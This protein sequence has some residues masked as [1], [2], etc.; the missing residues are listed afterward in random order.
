ME[1]NKIHKFKEIIDN[2]SRIVIIQADNPDGDSLGSSIALEQILTTLGK[3][4]Y[5]YCSVDIPTYLRYIPAWSRVQKEL[6]NNFDLSI[7]VDTSTITLLDNLDPLKLNQIKSNPCIML[8]HHVSDASIDFASLYINNETVST[9]ELIYNISKELNLELNNEA[10]ESILIAILSDS[11]GLTTPN[12][13]PACIRT[14]AEI[15]EAGISISELEEKRR[16][17]YKK[18]VDLTKYKGRLLERIETY[19]DDQLAMLT[20]PYDEIVRFSPHYN[21]PMLVMEDMRLI[22]GNKIV[23]ALKQYNDG[24]I[25]G[26]IRSNSGWPIAEKLAANFGGG[27]HDYSS[28][29][30][31]YDYPDINELKRQIISKTNELLEEEKKKNEVI[32]YPN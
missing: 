16:E 2:A 5:M 24:R 17:T 3:D 11:L 32:Q 1:E 29:F 21:P 13:T 9:S 14:V 7:I 23:I 25:L 28:G 19:L 10:L 30:K 22:E 18:S 4:V 12:V 6:P 15:V 26:K 20:I 8:D 31:T 27:G